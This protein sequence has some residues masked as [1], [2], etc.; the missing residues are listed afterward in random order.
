MQITPV[1]LVPKIASRPAEHWNVKSPQSFDDIFA[2]A[3]NVWN[4]AVLADPYALVNPVPGRVFCELPID[5]G[6][7]VEPG[8]KVSTST[9]TENLSDSLWAMAGFA[10]SANV[11][12][13]QLPMWNDRC[14]RV[15]ALN[16]AY[17]IATTAID[18]AGK[19]NATFPPS[20]T[21]ENG[22]G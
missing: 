16:G 15:G 9:V 5:I 14:T 22:T 4:R 11:K 7:I 13:A 10:R 19:V 6:S 18:F 3:M 12:V 20:V 8:R 17:S 21:P 2:I 1:V